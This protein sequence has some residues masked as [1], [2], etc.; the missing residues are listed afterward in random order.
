VALAVGPPPPAR[1][2]RLALVSSKRTTDGVRFTAGAVTVR[3]GVRSVEP[4][5]NL[6][7]QLVNA[8]GRVVRELTPSGGATDLLPG[9]YAYTLTASARRGLAK[10]S[11]SFVAR[12]LG[13]AGGAPV[14][15][16]SPSFTVR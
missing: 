9:E 13:P 5:G 2:G 15:R 4:L 3:S 8:R 16:K 11:Y 14:T 1:L 12:G 6:R 7:L 10:G